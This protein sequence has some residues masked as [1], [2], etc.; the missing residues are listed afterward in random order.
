MKVE[1]RTPNGLKI[2]STK[3][4]LERANY[5]VLN[6]KKLNKKSRKNPQIKTV[7][8]VVVECVWFII[9]QFTKKC[10]TET[11]RCWFAF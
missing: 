2:K 4:D 9:F 11:N 6:S 3:G 7:W 10:N 1:Q 5:S 8:K